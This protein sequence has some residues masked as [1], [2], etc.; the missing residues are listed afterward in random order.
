[1][2]DKNIEGLPS[3]ARKKAPVTAKKM[4]RPPTIGAAGDTMLVAQRFPVALVERVDGWATDN[5][6]G[7][8]EA[9]RRLVEQGLA[10]GGKR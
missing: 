3:M 1:L 4:G 6:V 9:M 2:L 5:G 10:K 7:R 8:S